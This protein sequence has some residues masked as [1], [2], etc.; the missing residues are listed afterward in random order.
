MKFPIKLEK[1]SNS[2]KILHKNEILRQ[3]SMEP[4]F[5]YKY[6]AVY[7]EKKKYKTMTIKQKYF[8]S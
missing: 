5:F 2:I 1:N 3:I 8:L 4:K 7:Y 6:F